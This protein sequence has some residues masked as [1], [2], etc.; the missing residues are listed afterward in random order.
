MSSEGCCPEGSWGGLTSGDHQAKGTVDE[1]DGLKIYRVG[2]SSKCIIWNYDIFGFDGGR[3]RQLCDL[4]AENGYMVIMPDFY[5]GVFKDPSD[6]AP[7]TTPDFLKDHTKWDSLKEDTE[8][9]VL[10]YA[11]KHGAETYGAIGTCWG[12]YMVLRLAS[13][14]NMKAGVSM[15][16]SHTPI[17][18]LLGESEE[19]LL[20]GSLGTPQLFMP[21]GNDAP[22]VKP[23]GL[24]SQTLGDKLTIIEFPDMVHGWTTRGD[25]NRP[26]VKRDVEKAL[27]EAIA[28]FKKYV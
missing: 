28:F 2:N 27:K 12:S 11:E 1:V 13:Y 17:S 20:K 21:A 22:E 26:E 25:M 16:P 23:G 15:H 10:P 3:T 8:K 24:G 7:P 18:Q 6:P 4:I 9:R 14:P 5:R 19:D